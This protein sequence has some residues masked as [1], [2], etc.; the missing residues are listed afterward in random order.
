[1]DLQA[2][3]AAGRH[4]VERYGP[5]GFRVGGIVYRGSVLVFADRTLEWPVEA[6]AVT[7]ESLAPVFA[8]GD[9]ELL[10]VGLGRSGGLLHA[11]LRGHLHELGIGFESMDTGAACRT[12]NVLLGEDRRVAAALIRP[13]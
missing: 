8:H 1:M 2:V 5:A 10:V 9:I 3:G 7:V 13:V 11:K 12:Y 4:V 6:A